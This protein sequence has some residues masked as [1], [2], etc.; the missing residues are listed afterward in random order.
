MECFC[1]ALL[2]DTLSTDMLQTSVTV[3]MGIVVPK[4]EDVTLGRR[5]LRTGQGVSF[6]DGKWAPLN[7]RQYV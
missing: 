7:I 1:I 3:L 2:N 6:L 5:Q 4:W